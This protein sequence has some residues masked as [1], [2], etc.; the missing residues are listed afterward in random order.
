[1]NDL[2]LN[3]NTDNSPIV[4]TEFVCTSMSSGGNGGNRITEYERAAAKNDFVR[5]YNS[6]R[7]YVSCELTPD[8]WTTHFR[9]TP[10]VDKPR[11]PIINEASFVLESGR[12]GARRV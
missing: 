6:N 8:T 10:Y 2:K 4:G 5:Y 7:G 11:S 12:P 1:M 3:F 9:V